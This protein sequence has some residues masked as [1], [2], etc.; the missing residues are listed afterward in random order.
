MA[1]SAAII[2]NGNFKSPSIT[3]SKQEYNGSEQFECSE[4]VLSL[5]VTLHARHV[6]VALQKVTMRL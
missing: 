6:L 5:K 1:W 3:Y 2:N 4:C